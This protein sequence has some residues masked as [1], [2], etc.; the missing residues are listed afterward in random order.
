MQAL[1]ASFSSAGGHKEGR[2][3]EQKYQEHSE[4]EHPREL[5]EV[6]HNLLT[7]RVF[8]GGN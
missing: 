6:S 7:S 8:T 1:S 5:G 2:R 3:L 4:S